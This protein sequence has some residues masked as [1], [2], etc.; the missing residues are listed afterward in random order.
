MVIFLQG[1]VCNIVNN[2]FVSY[3]RHLKYSMCGQ[4]S[5]IVLLAF[6]P[7]CQY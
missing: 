7:A 2:F 3:A 5:Y 4:F 1:F 6:D